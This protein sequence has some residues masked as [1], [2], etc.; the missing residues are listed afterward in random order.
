MKQDEDCKRCNGSGLNRSGTFYCY[1]C[2]GTGNKMTFEE[3][4]NHKMYS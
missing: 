2:M 1:R 3:R 4:K